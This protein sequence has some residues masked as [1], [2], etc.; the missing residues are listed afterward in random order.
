[1]TIQSSFCVSVTVIPSKS[2]RVSNGGFWKF[3][4]FRAL[5]EVLR[6][7]A[8]TVLKVENHLADSSHILVQANPLLP[9]HIAV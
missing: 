2:P 5:I 6:I 1:V 9:A 8:L 7:I 3:P 4:I